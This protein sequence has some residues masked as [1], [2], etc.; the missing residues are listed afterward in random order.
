M[1][2]EKKCLDHFKVF[3]E[4][5]GTHF[6]VFSKFLYIKPNQSW[7]HCPI[8]A[9]TQL[10]ELLL[11]AI[12]IWICSLH[13]NN[14][15]LGNK[16]WVPSLC[17]AFYISNHC[18]TVSLPKGRTPWKCSI[19]KNQTF[20]NWHFSGV[21]LSNTLKRIKTLSDNA[22][23]KI[24]LLVFLRIPENTFPTICTRKTPFVAMSSLIRHLLTLL[25]RTQVKKFELL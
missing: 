13:A 21:L 2:S 23:K 17:T 1:K 19:V 3:C 7:A 5:V 22:T 9:S 6:K 15:H 25:L 16:S 12:S 18:L 24:F 20:P 14:N 8:F 4:H 10:C 11:L